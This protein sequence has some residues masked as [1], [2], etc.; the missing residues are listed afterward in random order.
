[1]KTSLATKSDFF[2]SCS[3]NQFQFA[4]KKNSSNVRYLEACLQE[5]EEMDQKWVSLL[6]WIKARKAGKNVIYCC[7]H[8]AFF[9]GCPS[10]VLSLWRSAPQRDAHYQN[11]FGSADS[12][13]LCA[14]SESQS[15]PCDGG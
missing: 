12:V 8:E 5:E 7:I 4:E 1:M 13:S 2:I 15:G 3:V 10:F 14:R 6:Q 9:M 11:E